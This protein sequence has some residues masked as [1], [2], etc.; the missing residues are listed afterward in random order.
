MNWTASIS[1]ACAPVPPE[2]VK[3]PAFWSET[4]LASLWLG[5]PVWNWLIAAAI[6]LFSLTLRKPAGRLVEAVGSR[7]DK[8]ERIVGRTI[9]KSLGPAARLLVIALAFAIAFQSGLLIFNEPGSL[10]VRQIMDTFKAVILCISLA[11]LGAGVLGI[12]TDRAREAGHKNIVTIHVF[13]RH[14]IFGAAIVIGAFMALRIW[15]FDI[16]GLLAGIGIGGLALSLA[17][18]DTFSNLLAGLTIMTDHSFAIGDVISSPDVEGI[19]EDIGMR[20]SKVRSFTQALVTVPNARLSNNTVTNLSRMTRRRIR[21][22]I[23]LE[24]GVT[25]DQIRSLISKLTERM[26]ARETLYQENILICL[27]KFSAS[28]IDVL[29][30]CFSR[31][32]D[33]MA[34]LKEQESILLEIMD[35]MAEENLSFAFNA[36]TVHLND[37]SQK[38][39][40]MARSAAGRENGG[41]DGRPAAADGEK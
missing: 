21:L 6:L 13:Y 41:Q 40:V 22:S 18:Q 14:A 20:S 33:F 1:F 4:F 35:V 23:G 34:F 28:S 27:E 26:Q 38:Q 11:G 25:P 15:G 5:N 36:M 30:Q 2:P 8:G 39:A 16:S 32:I 19:V 12:K 9:G 7:F 3:L 37:L 10:A 29:F 17:A 24:Y 31:T